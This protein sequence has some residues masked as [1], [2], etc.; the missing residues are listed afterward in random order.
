MTAVAAAP[1]DCATP[2][3]HPNAVAAGR[4]RLA[5]APDPRRVAALFALLADPT[6]ARMLTALG[7][8]ELCV[9]DLAAV[10]AI[11]RSTV[12]HQL[13][14]LREGGVVSRRREGKVV[15]YALADDHVRALL[16]MGIAHAAEPL[17]DAPEHGASRSVGLR[18]PGSR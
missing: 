1:D 11:N 16:D 8:G 13:R 9:C 5:A 15:F 14:T 4:A 3:L 7:D 2:E 10:T 18:R 17:P 12:S 6:R